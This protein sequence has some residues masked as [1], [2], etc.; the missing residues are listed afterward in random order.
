MYVFENTFFCIL[1]YLSS[2]GNVHRRRIKWSLG[3]TSLFTFKSVSVIGLGLV[4]HVL[5]FRTYVDC[6]QSK[7]TVDKNVILLRSCERVVS[8]FFSHDYPSKHIL[9]PLARVALPLFE[10]SLQNAL[11]TVYIFWQ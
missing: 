7:S 4:D 2:H 8:T 3:L 1:R 6:P 5:I 10:P 9:S 11:N